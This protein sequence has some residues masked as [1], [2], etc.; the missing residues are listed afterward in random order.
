MESTGETPFSPSNT[1]LVVDDEDIVLET[2]S[3]Y[4]EFKGL[5]PIPFRCDTST[6]T[7]VDGIMQV[8]SGPGFG[9]DLDPDWVGEAEVITGG[10]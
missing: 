9:I 7:C 8:P 6:L 10:A 1:I 2:I 3:E 4:L 5:S